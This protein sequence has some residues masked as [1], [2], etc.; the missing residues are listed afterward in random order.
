MQLEENVN[1]VYYKEG[2]NLKNSA[3]KLGIKVETLLQTVVDDKKLTDL[4]KTELYSGA[5]K[6]YS[7]N[8]EKP[9]FLTVNEAKELR[10]DVPKE[11]TI[12]VKKLANANIKMTLTHSNWDTKDYIQAKTEYYFYSWLDVIEYLRK[13]QLSGHMDIPALYQSFISRIRLT[14]IGNYAKQSDSRFYNKEYKMPVQYKVNMGYNKNTP[15]NNMVVMINFYKVND[16]PENF[17]IC[18]GNKTFALDK[19]EEFVTTISDNIYTIDFKV[20]RN[21]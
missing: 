16:E 13:Y 12:L 7:K 8:N 10:F 4:E 20:G 2:R 18:S 19:L 17:V 15:D 1:S 21:I 14:P 5:N 6:I 3:D 11:S 9:L